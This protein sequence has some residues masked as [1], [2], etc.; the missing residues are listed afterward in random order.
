MIRNVKK[1]LS[2]FIWNVIP[3]HLSHPLVENIANR[4]TVTAYFILM[5]SFLHLDLKCV[6]PHLYLTST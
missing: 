3:P 5:T 6:A 1:Y 4:S 2:G